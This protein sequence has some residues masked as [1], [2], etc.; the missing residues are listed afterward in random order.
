MSRFL[1]CGLVCLSIV[2]FAGCAR[3]GTL[4]EPA[5]SG[6]FPGSAI[7]RAA[8]AARIVS[9]SGWEVDPSATLPAELVR[10]GDGMQPG[11][12]FD[13]GREVLWDDIAHYWWEIP[14]GSGP[15]DKIRLHRVVRERRPNKPIH[16]PEAIF[17]QHGAFVGFVKFIFG[18][19]SAYTPDDHSVAILLAQNDID[20]WG[21]DQNWVLVPSGTTDFSFMQNWGVQNQVDNLEAGIAVA[22]YVRAL[23]GSGHTKVKLLG[24]SA[25]AVLGYA[26]LSQETQ[27]PPGQ[28]HIEAFIPVDQG[29]KFNAEFEEIRQG[30]CASVDVYGD[31]L[32]AGIYHADFGALMAL[33][34]TLARTDPGG[35]SP[36][37]PGYTNRQVLLLFFTAPGGDT[38]WM[39]FFAGIF[40]GGF[41]VDSRYTDVQAIAEFAETA[42]PYIPI[43]I[44]YDFAVSSCDEEDVPFD[45]HLGE[46]R[47]PVLHVA[48][49]GGWGRAAYPTLDRIGS[50]DKSIVT[51]QFLSDENAWL[52]FGHVDLWTATENG[53]DARFS[54]WQPILDWIETH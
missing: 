43:R 12:L 8:I 16:A 14:V 36:I 22:R 40:E 54:A 37:M 7:D 53:G 26:L 19:A 44:G 47:V 25:G 1:V 21:I 32:E 52:D 4:T 46:I 28:R 39:H 23:T 50:P 31:M 49:A 10:P 13:W 29:W 45:D 51:V 41:P 3:E 18:S 5:T 6:A 30:F 42:S 27:L 9:E 34:G 35:D 15:Y 24:Y 17:L 33:V 38:P 20:V 2:L 11:D 48:A